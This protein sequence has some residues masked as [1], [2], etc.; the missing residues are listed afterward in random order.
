MIKSFFF[1]GFMNRCII[2][3]ISNQNDIHEVKLYVFYEAKFRRKVHRECLDEVLRYLIMYMILHRDRLDAFLA[4][5]YN[6][7]HHL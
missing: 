3:A 5:F 2:S 7:N 6:D 1:T 4:E